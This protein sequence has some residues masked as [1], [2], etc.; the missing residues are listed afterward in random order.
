MGRTHGEPIDE[1]AL[2]LFLCDETR[3]KL[4]EEQKTFAREKRPE[5]W[6]CY[7]NTLLRL[8]L[9]GEMLRSG[10]VSGAEEYRRVFLAAAVSA[11]DEKTTLCRD[12]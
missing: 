2:A 12:L 11:N 5:V 10:M 6:D 8:L 3:G 4:T 7:R 1:D 9:C